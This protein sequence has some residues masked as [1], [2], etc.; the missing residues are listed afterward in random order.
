MILS[1]TYQCDWPGCEYAVPVNHGEHLCDWGWETRTSG[2]VLCNVHK[3][4]TS[5]CLRDALKPIET[6]WGEV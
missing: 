6:V 1:T 3:F 2:H 5:D 4:R